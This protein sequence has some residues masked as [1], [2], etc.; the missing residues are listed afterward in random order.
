MLARMSDESELRARLQT[1]CGEVFGSDLGAHLQR[2]V[3]LVVVPPLALLDGAVA[4]ARDDTTSVSAWLAGGALR[5]PSPEER[6]AWPEATQRRW[7]AVVV[8]PFVLVQDL[9]T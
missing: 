3:V 8:Q 1:E 2:D 5:R 6:A 7:L 4:I 9:E